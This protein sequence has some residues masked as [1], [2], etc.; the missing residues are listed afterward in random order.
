M[1]SNKENDHKFIKY[2]KEASGHVAVLKV[3]ITGLLNLEG[4]FDVGKCCW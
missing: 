4:C 1:Q 3:K 2:Y